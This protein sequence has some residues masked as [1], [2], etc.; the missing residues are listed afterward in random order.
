VV[1][2]PLRSTSFS[3]FTTLAAQI[4]IAVL[5]LG[6][7]I[8]IGRILGPAGRGSVAF[9]TTVGFISSWLSTLGVDQS[10]SNMGAQAPHTRRMLAGNA[11]VLSVIFGG[12]AATLVLGGT[13]VFPQLQGDASRGLLTVVML[14]VP[15]LVLQIYL[16]QLTAAQYHFTIGNLTAI[17]PAVVN[18]VGNVALYLLGHLSVTSAVLTW[19]IGQAIGTLWLCWYVHARLE[20]FGRPSLHLAR[21]E[22][23]FGIRA[24]TSHTMN[25]GNYR[26]DQWIMGILS[27]PQQLGLYSVAVSWSEA[28]FLIPQALMQV[29]RPDL[30]RSQHHQAGPSAA[31]VFRLS[32]LVTI[33]LCAGMLA[34]APILCVTVFGDQFQG[35]VVDL[36]IVA[37]GGFGIVAVKLLGSALTAQGRPLRE[38][39]AVG[40]TFVTVLGLDFLLIP[41]LGG[42]GASIA[43]AVGYSA[44]GLAMIGIFCVTM[45][46]KV[47]DLMP[48]RD[49]AR[50]ILGIL[51]NLRRGL[52]MAVSRAAG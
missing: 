38:S 51:A 30:A 19:L 35:S 49:T 33:V 47:R 25:L 44:G 15:L 26:A 41:S 50:E 7:V 17:V 2:G 20:G 8:V 27:T 29:Q 6:N 31:F 34:A 42:E 12:F 23:R 43:S 14:N 32:I 37:L 18:I 21:E 46:I 13:L 11:V 22:I 39:L 9:L 24:H 48:T 45:K 16:R 52:G 3:A 1:D 4:A 5:A 36:R 10:I 28:L 40:T